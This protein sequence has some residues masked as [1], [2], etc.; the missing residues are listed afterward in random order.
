MN[1]FRCSLSEKG[2]PRFFAVTGFSVFAALSTAAFLGETVSI[3]AA[4]L[5]AGIAIL[6]MGIRRKVELVPVIL[7]SVSLA[8]SLYAWAYH[9]QAEP[10]EV[11]DQTKARIHAT[12]LEGPEEENHKYYYKLKVTRVE[13][14]P[15]LGNFTVRF[16]TNQALFCQP[17]DEV[18]CLAGFYTFEE[19]GLYSAK[20]ARLAKGTVMGAYLAEYGGTFVIPAETKSLLAILWEVR[21]SLRR[22]VEGLFPQEEASLVRAM[23]LGEKDGLSADVES[24]FRDIGASHLLVISGLH[25]SALA[26]FFSLFLSLF[27]LGRRVKNLLTAAAVLLFLILIGFPFSAGRSGIML[28]LFLFADCLGREAD[29]LNSLGFALLLIGVLNPFSGGDVGLALS[30]LSTLGILKLQSGISRVINR[31]FQNR[32]YLR[33]AA[34]P[35]TASLSVSLACVLATLPVQLLVFDGFSLLSPLS[36][37]LL[38]LP[39]TLLLYTAVPAVVLSLVPWL[40]PAAAPFRLCAG[41][42]AQLLLRGADGLGRL[43]VPF[44]A[45]SQWGAVGFVWVLGGALAFC[46]RGGRRRSV[47]VYAAGMGGVVGCLAC[48]L[49]NRG[50]QSGTTLAVADEGEASCVVLLQ[51]GKAAVLSLDG[52]NTGAAASILKRANVREITSLRLSADSWEAAEAARRLLRKFSVKQVIR[53]EALYLGKELAGL[54]EGI[55]QTVFS[56]ELSYEAMEGLEVRLTEEGA[57]LTFSAEG[58]DTAVETGKTERGTCSLLLTNQVESSVNSSFTVLQTDDIIEETESGRARF[59]ISA[60]E[61]RII[62]LRLKDGTAAIRRED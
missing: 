26:A 53:Q 8:F 52:Y 58:V 62:W 7:L 40:T 27:R 47:C 29:S 6:V 1:R 28:L 59:C 41:L 16:S 57:L 51:D 43:P 13:E 17:G 22:C 2:L 32:R 19:G 33:R 48:G 14:V 50:L 31:P 12:V 46:R 35:L 60:G 24:D 42:L 3:A 21:R 11:L 25:L 44:A 61:S 56:E 18:E 5:T 36:S 4:V 45:V 10:F 34:A 54:M 55:P 23:L 15:Q 20:N 9:I 49:V 30:A 37:L 39:G 38:V